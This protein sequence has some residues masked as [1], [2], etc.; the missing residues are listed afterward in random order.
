M[1]NA[2]IKEDQHLMKTTAVAKPHQPDVEVA[3]KGENFARILQSIELLH[4]RFLDVVTAELGHRD[5]ALSSVQALILS[6]AS[7]KPISAGELQALGH[8]EGINVSYNIGKL[9]EGGYITLTRPQWDK[10]SILI[11]L[12]SEGRD[13]A[14]LVWALIDNHARSLAEIGISEADLVLTARMLNELNRRWSV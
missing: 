14:Q 10:R 3:R 6:H 1:V 4:R 13:V 8:F 2:T 7:A 11:E 9:A 5:N 12:T